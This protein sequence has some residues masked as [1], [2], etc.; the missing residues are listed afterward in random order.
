MKFAIIALL[1]LFLPAAAFAQLLPPDRDTVWNPGIPGGIPNRSSVCQTID[2]SSFDNGALDARVGIQAAIARC[3]EGEVVQLSAGVFKISSG[4]ILVNKAITLRGAGPTQ[5]LLKAP[6]GNN[7]AVVVIGQRWVKIASSTDLTS[8]AM[9]G[10]NSVTVA[11]TAGFHTGQIILIDQL[12]DPAV[13]FWSS[14][15]D[16]NCRGW[17]S[18]QNRPL[19]QIMEIASIDDTKVSFT[20]PF[21][22]TF[23]TAYTAQLSRFTAHAIK[24]AGVEDLK[25]Y[26]GEGGD[27]GGNFYMELAAYSWLKNVESQYSVGGSVHLY[28][29]LRCV[30]RDS[31]FHETKDPNPGGAGYGID[32]SLGSSD[33]LIENNISWFFNKVMLMRAA[34]GGNVIAYNYFEDGFGAGYKTMQE[35][36]LNASHMT[37]THHVLFEGN[38]A[39]N[40]SGDARWG[41]AIYITYFR[42]HATTVRR[43]V[44]QVGFELDKDNRYGV[45]APA[46]HYWYSYFGNVIGYPGMNPNPRK[47]FEYEDIYPFRDNSAVPMFIFGAPDSVGT[48]DITSFD[49]QVA[50]TVIRDGNFDYASN[51][52]HWD[53]AGQK[54]PNSLYLKSK[55][56]FFQNCVWPWV[57]A[58]EPKKLHVLPA[59]ARFDGNSN[60][61]ASSTSDPPPKNEQ[62]HRRHQSEP[63]PPASEATSE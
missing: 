5:T 3:G 41:N 47:T 56:A 62:T 10:S 46:R 7:Q 51:T 20:T 38:E 2:A 15:C 58:S 14:D 39:F 31:Y 33:N 16:A 50:A 9:K 49:P 30:I 45:F 61:C 24:N 12:A 54:I 37:T 19:T 43:D 29:S 8:D 18:R 26:G 52:V 63:T 28:R 21:H 36:G 53:R 27:G 6:D 22:M 25:V 42:N 59:R 17:F 13:T 1:Q 44:A 34:G 11:N 32:I 57:N 35:T 55:P 60:A 40:F 23:N 48:K 4:P